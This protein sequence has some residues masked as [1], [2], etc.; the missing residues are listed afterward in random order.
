[1]SDY[2]MEVFRLIYKRRVSPFI[3]TLAHEEE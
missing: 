3:I 2:S 1:M